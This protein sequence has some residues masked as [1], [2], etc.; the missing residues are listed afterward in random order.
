[1]VQDTATEFI[2][3]IFKCTVNGPV[4]LTDVL[5]TF[6]ETLLTI[7]FVFRMCAAASRPKM[8]RIRLQRAEELFPAL[9]ESSVSVLQRQFISLCCDVCIIL[10]TVRKLHKDN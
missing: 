2:S 9:K 8:L 4:F 6:L 7:M 10:F 1:M 3:L 5:D